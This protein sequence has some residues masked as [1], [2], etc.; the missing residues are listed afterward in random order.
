MIG[1]QL[2]FRQW[3]RAMGY[4]PT[5][6]DQLADYRL[7]MTFWQPSVNDLMSTAKTRADSNDCLWSYGYDLWPYDYDQLA[8]TGTY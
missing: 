5:T 2:T 7:S 8:M 1:Y 3:P 4:D 6:M